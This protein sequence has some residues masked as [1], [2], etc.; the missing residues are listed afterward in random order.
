MSP[1][2]FL[3]AAAATSA[4][5]SQPVERLDFDVASI[6]PNY[7]GRQGFDGFEVKHGTLTVRNVSLKTLIAAA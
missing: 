4:V 7:S 1:R 5:L 3:L 2:I 6:K